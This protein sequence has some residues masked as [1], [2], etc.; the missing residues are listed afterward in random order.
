MNRCVWDEAKRLANIRKHGIDFADVPAVFD[1]V[2]L[3][4]ED[5]RFDHGEQRFTTIGL[6][7]ELVILVAHTESDDTIRII[8]ARK[9]DKE[10]APQYFEYFRN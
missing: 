7:R 4:Y 8:H 6:L 5:T 10:T 2:T 9:A 1:R 3:T